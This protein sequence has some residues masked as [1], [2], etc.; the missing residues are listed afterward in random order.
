MKWFVKCFEKFADFDGRACRSEFWFF[1]LF[2]WLAFMVL[3]FAD[4]FIG[5]WS[6]A[7]GLGILSTIYAVVAILPTIAVAIRRVH[8]GGYCG[9]WILIGLIPGIGIFLLI[10]LLVQP[11]EPT[12]NQYGEIPDSQVVRS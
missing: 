1:Y 6:E 9:W 8:D 7:L 2:T 3:A 5:T 11:S 4:L 10:Y 12:A